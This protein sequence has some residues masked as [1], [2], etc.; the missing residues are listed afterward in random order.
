[1][2]PYIAVVAGSRPGLFTTELTGVDRAGL[3][4]FRTPS[5][6]GSVAALSF[7]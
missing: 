6:H 5:S 3:L 7:H 4:R 1:L 2:R